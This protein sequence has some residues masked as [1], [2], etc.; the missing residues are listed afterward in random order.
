MRMYKSMGGYF[1]KA[2]ESC[3]GSL[4]HRVSDSHSLRPVDG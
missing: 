2:T 4:L 3:L 1:L